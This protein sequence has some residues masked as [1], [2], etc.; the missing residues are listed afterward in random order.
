VRFEPRL[1]RHLRRRANQVLS[2]WRAQPVRFVYAPQ[3]QFAWPGM[4]FDE[5]RGER[6][7]T[8]LAAEGLALREQVRQPPLASYHALL[9]VHGEAY[10]EA[11]QTASAMERIL[12]MPV[13]ERDVQ[14]VL[15]LQRSMTGGTMLATDIA[16]STGNIAVNLGGGFHHAHAD[17]GRGFCV[18]NDV[19]VAIAE[20][21]ALG[22]HGRVLVVDLDLHDGDGTRALFARDNTVHTLSIHNHHWGDTDA[23]EST[24]VALG[25]RVDDA[26]YL[27][28]VHLHLG[29]ALR[30]FR[31]RLV[32][33]LAGTDPAA[34]DA[35][36]VWS[37]SEDGMLARDEAVFELVRHLAPDAALV[38]AL[39]GGYGLRTWRYTARSLAWLQS[40]HHGFTVP[41]NDELT[42]MRA[43]HL[44]RLLTPAELTSRA[45]GEAGAAV[46]DEFG[47]PADF[48]L[49]LEDLSPQMGRGGAETRLLGY[50]SRQG[51]E[52]ALER[53]GFLGRLRAKGFKE[54]TLVCDFED[55]DRQ[56]VTI[57]GDVEQRERLVELILHRERR[58]IPGFELLAIDWML[59]QNPR[60]RFDEQR[61]R[62]PGQ[63]HPGLGL[64]DELVALLV[65]AC[66]RVGLAGLIVTP[67]QYHLAVHWQRRLRFV[68]PRDGARLR[69]LREALGGL[70]LADGSAALHAGRVLDRDTGKP[71]RH[72]PAPMV[73]PL[74]PE[75]QA[76]LAG[77]RYPRAM[78][79]AAEEFQFELR[80]A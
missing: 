28:A 3:Y 74:S 17:V 72:V 35:L 41:D 80:P 22:F 21:R 67:S 69:A 56:S 10:L 24:S 51:L 45:G 70:S 30:R 7:L 55:P 29:A 47:L 13:G 59:L 46:D 76:A 79:E 58:A 20:Q 33:F 53:H 8:A 57:F 32:Y 62:L 54:P 49:T 11:A 40:G 42:L 63:E 14:R 50:Y 31:P 9:R 48:G 43:R 25:D 44:A 34:D 26:A 27:D 15:D 60:E 19:A 77:E 73:L 18:F 4:P 75:L 61:P 71:T 65:V 23:V 2:R 64:F 36:G 16:L 52:L 12:G 78:D 6:V 5:I 37:V 66:E 68:D 1:L 38:V 39:A